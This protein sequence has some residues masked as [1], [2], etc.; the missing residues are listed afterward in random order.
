M[1]GSDF[2]LPGGELAQWDATEG[3]PNL[4]IPTLVMRGEFDEVSQVQH[5]LCL[6][7]PLQLLVS[8]LGAHAL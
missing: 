2:L 8:R 6:I 7:T 1:C 3:L 4:D 5:D